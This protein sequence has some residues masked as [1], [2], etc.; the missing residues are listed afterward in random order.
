MVTSPAASRAQT[1][2]ECNCF[3]EAASTAESTAFLEQGLGS[4]WNLRAVS[5]C[6]GT[7]ELLQPTSLLRVHTFTLVLPRPQ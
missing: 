7:A 4:S 6:S 3:Q 2:V 1:V 5:S